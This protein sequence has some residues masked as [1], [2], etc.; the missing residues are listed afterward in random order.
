MLDGMAAPPGTSLAPAAGP[1][2]GQHSRNAHHGAAFSLGGRRGRLLKAI[3]R[4][5][6]VNQNNV[7]DSHAGWRGG[8]SLGVHLPLDQLPDAPQVKLGRRLG[9]AA[10]DLPGPQV[11]VQH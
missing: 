6:T 5:V 8:P 4:F 11:V 2:L 1:H 10:T 3:S 7:D 9:P